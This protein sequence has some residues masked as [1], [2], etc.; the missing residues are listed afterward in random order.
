[1][2]LES[3]KLLCSMLSQDLI[4]KKLELIIPDRRLQDVS[5]ILK[6]ANTGGMSYYRIEGRGRIKAEAVAV[7]RGTMHYKPEFIPRLKVEVVIKDEQVEDL[8]KAFVNKIGDKIGGKIFV[9]LFTNRF[10]NCS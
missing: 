4:M 7:G 9:N 10:F 6:D 1:V 5:E 2:G 8:V 3:V